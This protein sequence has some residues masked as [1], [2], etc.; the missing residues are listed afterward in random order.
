MNEDKVSYVAIADDCG[1]TVALVGPFPTQIAAQ[2][3]ADREEDKHFTSALEPY[4]VLQ[5]EDP[6]DYEG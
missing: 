2:A 5:L 3:W 1:Y 4:V 6:A